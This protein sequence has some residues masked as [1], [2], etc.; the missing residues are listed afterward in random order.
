M[1]IVSFLRFALQNYSI[2]PNEKQLVK[3]LSGLVYHVAKIQTIKRLDFNLLQ[4]RNPTV[5]YV[6][7]YVVVLVEMRLI[8]SLQGKLCYFFGFN[9]SKIMLRRLSI[10]TRTCCIVSRSRT[11]TQL[12]TKVSL[13]TV[14]HIGV[15]MASC[16]R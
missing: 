12:S 7:V 2:S 15:P 5:V 3:P 4:N 14:T 11:V 10:G 1:V 9:S 13:S 8:A 16:L 6:A